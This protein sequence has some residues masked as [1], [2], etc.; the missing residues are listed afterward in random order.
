MARTGSVRNA[1]PKP[2]DHLVVM[3]EL[4]AKIAAQTG[5]F[6]ETVTPI[7]GALL[8]HLCEVF[9]PPMAREF[10]IV[11]EVHQDDGS[12]APAPGGLLGSVASCLAAGGGFAGATSLLK[13][14]Q[15]LL[16]GYFAERRNVA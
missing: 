8:N 16:G 1:C 14:A 7:V 15:S 10:A 3:H 4:I 5:Q 12:T 6:I 9:P 11:L 2:E 13:V